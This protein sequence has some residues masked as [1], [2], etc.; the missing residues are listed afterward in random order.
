MDKIKMKFV[1]IVMYRSY[2]YYDDNDGIDESY[3]IP[4]NVFDSKE[5]AENYILS[6]IPNIQKENFVKNGYDILIKKLK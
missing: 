2:D 3:W 6:K 5:K 4:D 1:Y